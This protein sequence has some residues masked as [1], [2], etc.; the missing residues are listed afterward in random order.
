M[1]KTIDD[2]AAWCV[3]LD[4]ITKKAGKAERKHAPTQSKLRSYAKSLQEIEASL[5]VK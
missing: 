5:L 1:R 3:V 2:V 4:A